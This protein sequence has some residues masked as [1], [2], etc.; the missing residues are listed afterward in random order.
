MSEQIEPSSNL[1]SGEQIEPSSKKI[2]GRNKATIKLIEA[3]HRIAEET[4]PITGRGVGYKLFAAGLISGMPEM[5]KVY[6][7]LTAAREDGTIPWEWIVDETRELEAVSTWRGPMVSS[8][9]ATCGRPN[10]IPSKSGPRRAPF[11]ASCG[12]C[13]RSTASAFAS[14]MALRRRRRCG[15]CRIGAMT[16]DR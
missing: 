1:T 11:A 7:A 10:P 2:R 16:I 4:R 6:R 14:C 5:P 9:G 15:T 13:S 3:M 8:T 12:Q